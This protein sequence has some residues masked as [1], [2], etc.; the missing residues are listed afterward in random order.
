MSTNNF[1]KLAEAKGE[2][3][4]LV[5]CYKP[6]LG[7]FIGTKFLVDENQMIYTKE[8]VEVFDSLSEVNQAFKDNTWQQALTCNIFESD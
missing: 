1:G 8:S 2:Q 4:P 3:L 5:I 7:Y 6:L